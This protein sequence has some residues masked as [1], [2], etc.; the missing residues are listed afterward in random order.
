[1]DVVVAFLEELWHPSDSVDGCR[2]DGI[3]SDIAHLSAAFF[4]IGISVRPELLSALAAD[5]LGRSQ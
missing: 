3:G 4:Q 2:R 5:F 1:M